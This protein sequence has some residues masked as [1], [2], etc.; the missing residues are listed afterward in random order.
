MRMIRMRMEMS[1]D[2]DDRLDQKSQSTRRVTVSVR[3]QLSG[4]IMSE[5]KRQASSHETKE[6]N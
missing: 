6:S 3:M 5:L 4:I 2:N 1:D